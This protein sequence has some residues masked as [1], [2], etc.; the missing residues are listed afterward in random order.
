MKRGEI[1]WADLPP[2]I[3]RRPVVLLSRD[4]AYVI[5]THVTVAQITSRV[6]NIP[7]EILLGPADGLPRACTA[8]L[9]SILTIRKDR[10]QQYITSLRPAKLSEVDTAIHFSLALS[11]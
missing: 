9:D 10:L 4:Q 6:G 1:W 7:A 5:R 8:N 11:Y 2:P 3:G